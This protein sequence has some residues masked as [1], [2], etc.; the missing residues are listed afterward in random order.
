MLLDMSISLVLIGSGGENYDVKQ[1]ASVTLKSTLNV[2]L[3][4]SIP[5]LVLSA[6]IWIDM[7]WFAYVCN[8]VN[9]GLTVIISEAVSI[10]IQFKLPG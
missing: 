6:W 8:S 1:Y 4:S 10:E 9:C 2:A 3:L 5:I 7:F